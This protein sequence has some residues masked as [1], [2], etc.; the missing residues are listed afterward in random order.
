MHIIKN[1][2]CYFIFLLHFFS[3]LSA[4]IVRGYI[5]GVDNSELENV[6]VHFLQENQIVYTTLS[7]CAGKFTLDIQEGSYHINLYAQD[8]ALFIA[9]N[10]YTGPSQVNYFTMSQAS[11]C[12]QGRVVDDISGVPIQNSRVRLF[13]KDILSFT[14]TTDE[15]GNFN[16]P[17]LSPNLYSLKLFAPNY[18]N[19]HADIQVEESINNTVVRM[20]MVDGV[21]PQNVAQC[22]DPLAPETCQVKEKPKEITPLEPIT[23]VQN[24]V[25]HGI[26]TDTVTKK[27][28]AGS[29]VKGSN[30]TNTFTEYV[31]TGSDGAYHLKGM[32]QDTFVIEVS[33]AG[34]MSEK[35][36]L[37]TIDSPDQVVTKHFSLVSENPTTNGLTGKV[38]V[39]STLLEE[40]RMH[41]IE[42]GPSLSSE[43]IGFKVYR[44]GALIYQV[45]LA[46][47]LR[48]EDHNRDAS[49]PDRY[50][51]TSLNSNGSESSG[52][53]LSLL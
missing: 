12:I 37:F 34:Y 47:P 8:Y 53:L 46:G 1:T 6:Q 19:Y 18:H 17:Y 22:D 43:V 13:L 27:P 52:R 14:A 24:N 35:S 26:I 44:N 5:Y 39:N 3:P 33:K 15:N 28:I 25:V 49:S 36:P 41:I 10:R 31:V 42:W 51:V 11:G 30:H 29:V 50:K 48:Y 7:D 16:T 20:Q 45:G 21:I 40:D 32:K 2:L 9:S 38:L 4:T 23:I